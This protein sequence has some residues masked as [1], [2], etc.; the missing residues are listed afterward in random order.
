[1]TPEQL[2]YFIATLYAIAC[3]TLY[4]VIGFIS[5]FEDEYING[6]RNG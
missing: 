5:K 3:F 4:G 1:M 2:P 6:E